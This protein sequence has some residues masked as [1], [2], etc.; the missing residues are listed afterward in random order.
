MRKQD[1]KLTCKVFY[2][3]LK[4]HEQFLTNHHHYHHHRRKLYT[5][6]FFMMMLII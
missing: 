4:L 3:V 6:I 2:N 5:L 1:I